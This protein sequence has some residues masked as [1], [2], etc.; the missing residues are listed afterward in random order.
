MNKLYFNRLEIEREEDWQKIS[1]E[2][3]YLSFPSHWKV[4]IIPPSGGALARFLILKDN[5]KPNGESLSVYLDWFSRLGCMKNPYW[6]LYPDSDGD[7]SRF[8]LE[9]TEALI[10]AIKEVKGE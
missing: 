9:E 7:C 3:P 8:A 2:I 6:E 5:T 1:S 10:A 4:K